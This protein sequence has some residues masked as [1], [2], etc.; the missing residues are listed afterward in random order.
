MS[1][2]TKWLWHQKSR[3]TLKT[4][5][6]INCICFYFYSSIGISCFIAFSRVSLISAS[7]SSISRALWAHT[8]QSLYFLNL[9]R[10]KTPLLMALKWS[11][12]KLKADWQSVKLSS[13]L[14][15]WNWAAARLVRSW[16]LS[17]LS[18]YGDPGCKPKMFLIKMN[19]VQLCKL[20][21]SFQLP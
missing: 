16:V 9:K 1:I 7:L 12:F 10:H 17:K 19:Y 5:K 18:S 13:K 6:E 21:K 11:S 2:I 15:K 8:T 3:S 14:P 4:K 20:Q